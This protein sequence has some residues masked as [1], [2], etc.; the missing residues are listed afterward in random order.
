MKLPDG[1]IRTDCQSSC[2]T[3][4]IA[5]GDVNDKDSVVTR[6]LK[7]PRNYAVLAEINTRP[8]V[9]YLTKV[10]NRKA[11]PA[12]ADGHGGGH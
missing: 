6:L 5:F 11:P 3:N 9:T 8:A 12:P 2:P 1:A 4:A 7:D 10:R